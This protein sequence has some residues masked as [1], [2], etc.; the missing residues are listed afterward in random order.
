MV[1]I[2]A[3]KA[4]ESQTAHR[5]LSPLSAVRPCALGRTLRGLCRP[6]DHRRQAVSLNPEASFRQARDFAWTVP[7]G[8]SCWRSLPGLAVAAACLQGEKG[9]SLAPGDVVPDDAGPLVRLLEAADSRGASLILAFGIGLVWCDV[10]VWAGFSPRLG[11][12]RKS[13]AVLIGLLIVLAALSTGRRVLGETRAIASL[14]TATDAAKNV[15]FIVLDTVRASRLSLYGY[16]RDTTPNLVRW[17][18]KGVT[19]NRAL[20]PA[21]WTFPSHTCFFTGHWPLEIDTQWKYTLDTPDPTLA[22]FLWRRDTRPP[23][24]R[25]TPTA[26]TTRRDLIE[27][28]SISRTIRSR[29]VRSS[30]GRCRGSGCLNNFSCSSTLMSGSGSRFNPEGPAEVNDALFGWL[31]RRRT[32]RPFFAFVNY[33]DAHE[34]YIPPLDFPVH[35]NSTQHA[36]RLS[37]P[38]RL[39]RR[40]QAHD[41][42][43]RFPHGVRQL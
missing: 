33:F 43:A 25:R 35:G 20:A 7:A 40:E 8:M 3:E 38:D 39:R 29:P 6:G 21:P 13:S 27:A 10:V 14:P 16:G 36:P 17:A 12:V 4:E 28:S 34:P 37:I 23:D 5:V 19:Y 31:D 11:W 26:A 9:F 30:A 32:D 1:T 2:A 42:H 24:S 15:V 22:E 18:K 41:R